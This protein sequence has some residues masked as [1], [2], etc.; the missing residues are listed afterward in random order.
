MLQGVRRS[1]LAARVSLRSTTPTAK[2]RA[3]TYV[4]TGE[5]AF[6]LFT[7]V[8]VSL[9]PGFVLKWDEGG[10]SNYGLHIKTAVPYT[11]GLGL[12]VLFSAW[13]GS[14]YVDRDRRSRGLRVLLY[15]YAAVVSSVLLSS[16]VYSLNRTLEDLHY[17][18]GGLLVLT[19]A[20]GSLWMYRL[21]PATSFASA[22]LL[23]QLFGDVLALLTGLGSLHALFVAEIVSNVGF[24]SLVVW[25]GRKVAVEDN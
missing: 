16:Y 15:T 24:A 7:V 23:V 10:M 14:L 25:T 12:L 5:C 19:V 18:L 13:A 21:W 20:A 22:L 1:S 3:V 9:H 6:L 8:C 17:M 11:L 2:W 4:A